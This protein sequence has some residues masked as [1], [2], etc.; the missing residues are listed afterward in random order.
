MGAIKRISFALTVPG[1]KGINMA[2]TLAVLNTE[3]IATGFIGEKNI[4]Y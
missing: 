2:A 3:V 4:D 1:G